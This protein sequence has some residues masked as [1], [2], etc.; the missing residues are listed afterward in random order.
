MLRTGRVVNALDG[1]IEIC[2]ERPEACDHCNACTGQKHETLVKIRGDAPLGSLVDVEMPEGQVLKASVLAYVLPLTLLILGVA[3]GMTV[4]GSEIAGAILGVALMGVS[5][6]LLR[7]FEK[8][9]RNDRKWQP[10]LAAVHQE[11][12]KAEWK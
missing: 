8:K 10:Y 4:F 11:G 3:L 1:E 5:Y 6:G 7:V 12:D 2:F 9:S